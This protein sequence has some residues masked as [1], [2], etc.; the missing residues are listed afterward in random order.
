MPHM[1]ADQ[2]RTSEASRVVAAIGHSGVEMG[3]H[4]DGFCLWFAYDQ[5][6][7]QCNLGYRRSSHEVCSLHSYEDRE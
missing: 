4:H 6:G 7:E 5:E 1:S 2:G 3:A